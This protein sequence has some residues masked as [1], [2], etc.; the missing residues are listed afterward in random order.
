[1]NKNNK[2]LGQIKDLNL[3][4]KVILSGATNRVQD[5]MNYIDIHVLSSSKKVFQMF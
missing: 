1:M 2:L 4:N 3:K 5:Y